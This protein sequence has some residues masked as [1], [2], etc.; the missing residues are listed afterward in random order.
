MMRA[1]KSNMARVNMITA[2]DPR[3]KS[4]VRGYSSESCEPKTISPLPF[5]V[6]GC[7]SADKVRQS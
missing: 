1:A 3:R 2:H 4:L 6:V 7:K 5:S